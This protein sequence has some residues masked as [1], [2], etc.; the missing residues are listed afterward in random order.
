MRERASP[1]E[2][3][4]LV[5]AK[6]VAAN[7]FPVE[8]PSVIGVDRESGR[9]LRLSPFPWQGNDTDP[10]V[11]KWGWLRATTEPDERDPRPE[12]LGVSGD[13][14]MTAYVEAKE[15]WRLRWPFVR[16]HLRSS[17]ESLT[18]LARQRVAGAG[19]VKP[20]D[21]DVVQLPLRY[22]FRCASDECTTTHELPVLDWELH[23]MSR[24]A[25]E[26]YGAQWATR[27][28]ESWGAGLFER[29][30]V[31]LLLSSYAQAPTRLYVAGLFTPPKTAEDE[32]AHAHHVEHRS[33][34]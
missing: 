13:L 4:V 17:V 22:R 26:R 3:D 30:D 1:H 18:E 29:F 20:A 28:R 27:F 11:T 9:L 8:R 23:E 14:A 21:G 32:H 24:L 19:F 2:R 10:P 31:H 12:T 33:H 25:R 6:T 15:G 34:R 16:P 5:L 7:E